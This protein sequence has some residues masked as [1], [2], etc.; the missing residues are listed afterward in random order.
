MKGKVQYL[1]YSDREKNAFKT[2]AIGQTI[3]NVYA[4][5]DTLY[6]MKYEYLVNHL[7]KK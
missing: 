3:R 5:I 6:F 7:K 2:D 4:Q 1:I